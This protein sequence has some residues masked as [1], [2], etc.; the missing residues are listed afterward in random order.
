[1]HRGRGSWA[2]RIAVPEKFIQIKASLSRNASQDTFSGCSRFGTVN[3]FIVWNK[4]RHPATVARDRDHL[5][6]FYSIK[7]RSQSIL[8][9]ERPYFDHMASQSSLV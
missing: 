1:M 2:T 7:Q 6:L 5:A 9:F 4:S 8:R 3:E